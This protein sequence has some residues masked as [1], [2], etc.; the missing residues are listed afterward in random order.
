MT[1]WPTAPST[2][3]WKRSCSTSCFAT[4]CTSTNLQNKKPATIV[5]GS[6]RLRHW[7][8]SSEAPK[9]GSELLSLYPAAGFCVYVAY[10]CGKAP[11]NTSEPKMTNMLRANFVELRIGEVRR[12]SLPRSWMNKGKRKVRS[13]EEPRPSVSSASRL[14]A[15]GY[16][17]GTPSLSPDKSVLHRAGDG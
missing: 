7:L 14:E 1:G 2:L 9:Y 4:I 5:C 15:R 10:M 6:S 8:H 3:A 12:I 16:Q 13:S 17:E 11:R